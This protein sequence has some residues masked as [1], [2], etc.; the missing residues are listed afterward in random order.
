[1]GLR[2]TAHESRWRDANTN[3]TNDAIKNLLD[4]VIKADVD[5]LDAAGKPGT[6]GVTESASIAIPFAAVHGVIASVETTE[7]QGLDVDGW[8]NAPPPETCK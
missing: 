3:D 4:D 7:G 8:C 2:R 6:D 1:M 5:A